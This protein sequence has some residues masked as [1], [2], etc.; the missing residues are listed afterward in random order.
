MKKIRL[1]LERLTVETFA[2]TEDDK[3]K[4]GTVRG[5]LSAYYELCHADDTWQQ[6]CT[7]EATCNAAT[8]YNCSAACGTGQCGG[9]S[10]ECTVF[11]RQSAGYTNCD[12]CPLG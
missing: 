2:T 1:D 11:V 12:D 9:G 5:H 6:S 3:A 10:G 8:C 7:C 4:R